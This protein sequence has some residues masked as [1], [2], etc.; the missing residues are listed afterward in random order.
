MQQLSLSKKKNAE[1]SQTNKRKN[2]QQLDKSKRRCVVVPQRD[3]TNQSN[4]SQT[5]NSADKQNAKL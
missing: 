1:E 4:E 2:A 5:A 3:N